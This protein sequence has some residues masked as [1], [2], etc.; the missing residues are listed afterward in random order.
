[1]LLRKPGIQWLLGVLSCYHGNLV[2]HCFRLENQR[3][4]EDKTYT[5]RS[6]V[7]QG[8]WSGVIFGA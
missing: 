3:F 8:A 1:M 5:I 2:W 6:S 4:W 7:G